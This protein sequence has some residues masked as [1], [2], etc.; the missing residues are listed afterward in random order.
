M[1]RQKLLDELFAELGRMA[2]AGYTAGLHI[3]RT[4]PLIYRNTYD[5]AWQREYEE[6]A[7][8][9]RDPTV[10]WGLAHAGA[11]RWSA[12]R[13]PDPFGVIKRANAHGL[14]YGIVVSCGHLRSR[15]IVGAARPDREFHDDEIVAFSGVVSRLHDASK[16]PGELTRAQ[17]EALRLIAEG[18]RHSAAADA[19]GIS[20]SA[21]KARLK[22]AK[23]KLAARTTT[24]AVQ[25]ARLYRFL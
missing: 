23:E 8:M 4:G 20:E 18:Y 19:L 15:S 16:P 17:I 14:E 25:I 24:E 5:A 1:S 13:L 7:F 3:R 9:L 21:L 2:P 6:N 10:F 12:I 11:T 22:A